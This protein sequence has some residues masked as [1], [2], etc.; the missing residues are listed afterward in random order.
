DF[1][2]SG[3]LIATASGAHARIWDA[4]SLALHATLVGHLKPILALVFHPDGR[5][6]FTADVAGEIKRWDVDGKLQFSLV[7]SNTDPELSRVSALS[8]SS[9]G[10]RLAAVNWDGIGAVW[11]AKRGQLLATLR[12]SEKLLY[13]V[14]VSPDGESVA[15]A[16]DGRTVKIWN[17]QTGEIS[18]LLEGHSSALRSVAYSTDGR[19][20]LTTSSDGTARLWSPDDNVTR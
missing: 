10:R 5:S 6:L 16:G 12:H 20:L 3:K 4:E 17:G 15:T 7:L 8:I 13:S 14:A 19:D 11:D 2:P 9:D 1:S 18:R